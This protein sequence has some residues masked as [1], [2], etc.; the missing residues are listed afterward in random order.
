MICIGTF[1]INNFRGRHFWMCS[2]L[3]FPLYLTSIVYTIVCTT[4]IDK[5]FAALLQKSTY[6]SLLQ[7]LL[8]YALLQGRKFVCTITITKLL[9]T[10]EINNFC[11]HYSLYMTCY[12]LTMWL[13]ELLSP[14]NKQDMTTKCSIH[15][16]YNN[17][18]SI[19]AI[20]TVTLINKTRCGQTDRQTDRRTDRHCDL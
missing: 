4:G 9:Y 17:S 7:L 14:L 5:S 13:I 1:T 6:H 11:M 8:L 20:T 10:N 12:R 15:L 2:I 16:K 18:N 3:Y 19:D